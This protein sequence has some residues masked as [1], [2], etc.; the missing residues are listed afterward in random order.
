MR[1]L[2]IGLLLL[3]AI[4][5]LNRS[6]PSKNKTTKQTDRLGLSKLYQDAES[7]RSA[8][9]LAG[10]L[11]GIAHVLE[12]D[13]QNKYATIVHVKELVAK[14]TTIQHRDIDIKKHAQGF[15]GQA[16]KV[17]DIGID[18]Y[19]KMSPSQKKDLITRLRQAA[20]ELKGV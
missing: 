19:T 5:A 14:A 4:L 6:S 3:V 8:K 2:G 1:Q 20:V 10:M 9:V 11:D 18:P 15:A 16:D 12:N 17:F 13:K 7:K